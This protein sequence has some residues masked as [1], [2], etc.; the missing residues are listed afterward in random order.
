MNR[1]KQ[2]REL[3][4]FREDIREKRVSAKSTTTRT[5]LETFEGF[6]QILKELSAKKRYL[7]VFTH[8]IAII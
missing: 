7:D 5:L 4:P 3:F 6:S 1:R 8:P 2:F